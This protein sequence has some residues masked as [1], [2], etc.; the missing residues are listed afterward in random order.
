M[1]LRRPDRCTCGADIAAG[2]RAAWNK[3]TRTVLCLSCVAA[4][5]VNSP[6]ANEVEP[7]TEARPKEIDVGRPGASA[8]AV[9]ERL[10]HARER[11][12]RKAHPKLGGLILALSDD[13]QSIRAWAA[14]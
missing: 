11:S 5:Q 6:Q 3:A 14:G 10:H 4:I 12:V 9:F 13:P 7:T 2:E 1:V 8:Q